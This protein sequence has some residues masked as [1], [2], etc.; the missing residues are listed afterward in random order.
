MRV[1]RSALATV[2]MP[3]AAAAM[4]AGVL[5]GTDHTA[6][7]SLSP[8]ARPRSQAAGP[9]PAGCRHR[10]LPEPFTGIA[11]NP[12]IFAHV[13]AF[14]RT[15][16]SPVS[17]VE[18]YN[19]FGRPFQRWEAQQ[20]VATGALPLIQL[21]P[22]HVSLTSVARGVY[23]ERIRKY[24]DAVK[25]FGC[26]VVLSFGHEMNGWWYPWGL[27]ATTPATFI[28]AW[29]HIHD[30]FAAQHVSNVIWSWD[31]SHLYQTFRTKSAS[32]A[33]EWYP[34][35][36]YVD[37]VGLDGYLAR[38]Q[39]FRGIF[40]HQLR[41]IRSVTGKP[42]YLAETGVAG[43]PDQVR[44]IT[45]LFASLRGYRLIGLVWFDLNRKQ[46]WRLEGR[47]AGIAAFRRAQAEL[48]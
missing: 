2:A 9:P 11:I 43:G 45:Q 3:F 48:R 25:A 24:A 29:R 14:R 21:N 20:A 38:G 4:M 17:V 13:E 31:P 18:F 42:V 37:W 26:Q 6:V 46:P 7:P 41:N 44:Q 30:V 19:P 36:R 35:N 39:T 5:A 16:D 8:P 15:T 33:S 27:P 47:P 1:K 23:D 10:P 32:P 28:A 22:R 12:Q 34:G 40:E